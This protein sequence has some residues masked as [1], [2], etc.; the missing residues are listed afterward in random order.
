MN[1]AFRPTVANSS[2][3]C[4]ADTVLTA[5]VRSIKAAFARTLR[6]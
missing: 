2:A 3:K 1:F 4:G 6:S 5:A